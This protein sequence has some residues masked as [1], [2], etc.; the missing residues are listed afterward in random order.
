[1]RPNSTE[2]DDAIWERQV[3]DLANRVV[4]G[5]AEGQVFRTIAH[6]DRRAFAAKGIYPSL[7]EPLH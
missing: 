3:A 1:M 5:Y 7:S 2:P 4:R 6:E